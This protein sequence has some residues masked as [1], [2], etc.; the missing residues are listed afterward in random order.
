MLIFPLNPASFRFYFN[1]FYLLSCSSNFLT[2][3][4]FVCDSVDAIFTVF[5]FIFPRTTFLTY[6]FICSENMAFILLMSSLL[7]N[8][9]PLHN[10]I[11]VLLRKLI[12]LL[13]SKLHLCSQPTGVEATE[14]YPNLSVLLSFYFIV[15][16]EFFNLFYLFACSYM[17]K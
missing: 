8:D 7:S 5:S 3:D 11:Q 16:I 2:V 14:S 9:L 10:C 4:K 12:S 17:I 13:L 1:S 6:S 15:K